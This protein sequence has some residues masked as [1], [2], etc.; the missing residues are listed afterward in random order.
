MSLFSEVYAVF[1]ADLRVLRRRALRA[2]ASTLVNPILYL[3][4][5]GYGLGR[6]VTFEGHSYLEFVVPGIIALTAMTS[7]FS[8]TGS[9][10]HID[11][12][13]YKCFDELLMAPISTLSIVLGKSLTGAV[14]GLMSSLAMAT[15]GFSISPTLR[16]SPSLPLFLVVLMIS[17]F[18]FSFLGVL[19]ALTVKSHQDMA[20]FS[21]FVIVPMSFLSGTFF[22]IEGIPSILKAALYI[23]PLTHSSQCLRA[24][25][26]NKPFP[27]ASMIALIGFGALF[28]AASIAAVRRTSA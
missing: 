9:K 1:W 7:S 13:Y 6:G 12:L 16:A 27:W 5:F 25:A 3:L 10:L 24:A 21:A 23:L 15:V 22:S 19:A 11:R 18:V 14:H 4:A 20:S 2:V 8:G 26:L 28:L 17:C